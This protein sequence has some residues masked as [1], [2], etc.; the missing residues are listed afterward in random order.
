MRIPI[1]DGTIANGQ[2]HDIGFHDID[3]ERHSSTQCQRGFGNCTTAVY[4][5]FRRNCQHCQSRPVG[6]FKFTFMQPHFGDSAGLAQCTVALAS[7][8]PSGGQPWRSGG[9]QAQP[10]S[11]CR[12]AITIP[13][14]VTSGS[15]SAQL[16]SNTATS[17]QISASLN[18]VTE[19]GDHQRRSC[20]YGCSFGFTV[21][22]H[23]R[24]G[25]N[26]AIHGSR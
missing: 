12:H 20:T 8:A 18:S 24:S 5:W 14:G 19:D 3:V 10:T 22:R 25:R 21:E 2:F 7:S 15:F 11:Q 17:V 9:L 4:E 26:A 16:N 6:I 1:P 13:A 23:S